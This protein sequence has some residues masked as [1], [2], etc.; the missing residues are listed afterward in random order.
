VTGATTRDATAA[1]LPAIDAL[2][3]E[4]FVATF[5]HL[6]APEDLAAFLD[7]FTLAAWTREFESA[8][9]RFR[10]A[11]DDRGMIGYAKIG[12]LT[13]PAQTDAK[14]VELRQLYLTER[15]KGGG[16]AQALMA[17]VIDTARERGADELWLSVYVDNHRARRFYER[18]GFETQGLYAF[19]V[20]NHL[21][22]DHLM[23][24]EL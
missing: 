16:V 12:D 7:G 4:S 2:F 19:K 1:D 13:L 18:Y 10:V 3:R 17:W 20:G 8:D 9:H 15:A 14:T 24:L 21:D 22:E 6:Y 23:R 5:G 11:E